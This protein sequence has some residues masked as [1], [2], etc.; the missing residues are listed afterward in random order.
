[1]GWWLNKRTNADGLSF[2]A[3][4]HEAGWLKYASLACDTPAATAELATLLV[5]ACSSLA[6]IA[7]A[8]DKS[9]DATAWE[10]KAVKQLENI[11]GKLWCK[12]SF[13]SINTA[14]GDSC[15]AEGLLSLLP[16][17]I[18]KLLL[19]D[20]ID[21]LIKKANEV[22]FGAIDIIPAV[23]IILGLFFADKDAAEKAAAKLIESCISGG[24]NDQRGKGLA[25]G[26]YFNHN[27]SAALLAV[28]SCMSK[29]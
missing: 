21:A 15:K 10:G 25:A 9:D 19:K 4:R 29:E 3:F 5:M 2:Y 14:T 18:S 26:T 28:L 16:L 11:I 23:L 20:T 8:L 1:M 22:D 27:A 24:I 12:D 7:T 13:V 17:Y 6:V